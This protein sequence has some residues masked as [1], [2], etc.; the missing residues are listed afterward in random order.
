VAMAVAEGI[1]STAVFAFARQHLNIPMR[2]DAKNTWKVITA[3]APFYLSG[4]STTIYNKID[5]S[6][7]AVQANDHEVGWYGAATSL[8]GLTLLLTPLISWVMM[9]L[10][11]RAAAQ[12]QDELCSMVRRAMELILVLTI[13][14]ALAMAVGAEVWIGVVFGA[15][16]APSVT[17]L[18]ILAP[19]FVIMYISIVCWCALTMMNMTWKLAF[20]FAS[21]IVVAPL[22][23]YLMIRPGLALL[24]NG[25][26][27]AAC[28]AATLGTELCVVTPMLIMLGRKM[29]DTRLLTIIAKTMAGVALVVVLDALLKPHLGPWRLLPD[30]AAYVAF[31]LLTR[32][33]DV[34]ELKEWI[35]IALRSRRE[36]QQE[37]G[38]S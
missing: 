23:N 26:G 21:G 35:Q 18:S 16:F 12:S 28:A 2:F 8:A 11:A 33:V 4:I 7:L 38:A 13:P 6:I 1:T 30:A 17:A 20:V 14:I 5:V 36:Q 24:G 34:R 27:G 29:M 3:S 10:F 19:V 22:L 25:G 9:P 32:A 37:S 15:E 31:V